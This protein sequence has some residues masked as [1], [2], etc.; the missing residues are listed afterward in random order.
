MPLDNAE[1]KTTKVVNVYYLRRRQIRCVANEH[2][3]LGS[4]GLWDCNSILILNPAIVCPV[5]G[6]QEKLGGGEIV[7]GQSG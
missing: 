6:S 1:A 7:A 4:L 5:E 2:D 3:Y